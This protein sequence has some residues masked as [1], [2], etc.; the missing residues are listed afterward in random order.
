MKNTY[1]NKVKFSSRYI[2]QS[3]Y[4]NPV[5]GDEAC[6]FTEANLIDIDNNDYLLLKSLSFITDEDLELLLPIV[7]PTSYMGS[8]TRPN[9]VKQ[10]FREYLN[11][12]SSLHGLQWW[13]IS[14]FLCSRGYAIPYMGLSVEKQIEYGWIKISATTETRN[15]QN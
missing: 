10:I 9:M 6:M 13:H 15:V 3:V 1:K 14:D 8:L 4:V 11:K 5:L 12:S 2:Y 7:Q